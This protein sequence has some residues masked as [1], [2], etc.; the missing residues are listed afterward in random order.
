MTQL[1]FL[2]G[3]RAAGLPRVGASIKCFVFVDSP[4]HPAPRAGSPNESIQAE[5]IMGSPS[6]ETQ[7]AGSM[8]TRWRSP[9][10]V[11]RSGLDV[12]VTARS[13]RPGIGFSPTERTSDAIFSIALY[14]RR[15]PLPRGADL[16]DPHGHRREVIRHIVLSCARR[17]TNARR[18]LAIA[19]EMAPG[20]PVQEAQAT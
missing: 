17:T 5:P 20:L 18:S 4:V 1:F 7:L 12:Q 2:P 19:L 3:I 15:W 9:N 10:R 14:A 13:V 6:V 16:P 11:C 8:R